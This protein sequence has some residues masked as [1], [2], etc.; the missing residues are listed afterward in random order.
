[1]SFDTTFLADCSDV[2]SHNVALRSFIRKLLP[3]GAGRNLSIEIVVLKT[4]LSTSRSDSFLHAI[5]AKV[6][7]VDLIQQQQGLAICLKVLDH[8]AIVY[9][10]IIR[11][12]LRPFLPSQS[13]LLDLPGVNGMRCSLQLSAAYQTMPFALGSQDFNRLHADLNELRRL[14]V[15]K[16]LAI[17][18]VDSSLMFG[19]PIVVHAALQHDFQ[20]TNQMRNFVETLFLH[21]QQS[22]LAIL[23]ECS[24]V[25]HVSSEN[26][27]TRLFGGQR[28]STFILMP[29]HASLGAPRSALIFRYARVV[30]LVEV[31][32]MSGS[33]VLPAD[34][35]LDDAS[36][37]TLLAYFQEAIDKL[38]AS[39]NPLDERLLEGTTVSGLSDASTTSAAHS[40]VGN[41]NWVRNNR[42]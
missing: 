41:E 20:A 35:K 23:V 33:T 36:G 6:N 3:F 8:S 28:N 22:Q 21:L 42:F 11:D 14:H 31:E 26:N 29:Q 37:T 39:D 24:L 32:P 15:R 10:Q 40:G 12:W 13:I 27:E 1:L 4:M 25:E 2:E 34:S 5:Q 19:V 38:Q 30:H 9:Q 16:A 18:S 17:A 7:S